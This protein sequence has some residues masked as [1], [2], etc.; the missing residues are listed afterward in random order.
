MSSPVTTTTT[1]H[2]AGVHNCVAT[3]M[4]TCTCP[5][6]TDEQGQMCRPLKT[7]LS[8]GPNPSIYSPYPSSRPTPLCP[9]APKP[10]Q[11]RNAPGAKRL[12]CNRHHTQ[13]LSGLRAAP[14]Q[15]RGLHAGPCGW[16]CAL[17]AHVCERVGNLLCAPSAPNRASVSMYCLS[18]SYCL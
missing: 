2:G 1:T 17:H 10:N 12:V 15:G 9:H 18:V 7:S 16:V 4:S 3:H 8:I 6:N 11:F 14:T 5:L 13:T